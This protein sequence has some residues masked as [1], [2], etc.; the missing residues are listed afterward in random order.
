MRGLSDAVVLTSDHLD[1]LISA[2]KKKNST[3][4]LDQRPEAVFSECALFHMK[5]TATV[6]IFT[7]VLSRGVSGDRK[8]P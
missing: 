1:C 2:K 4:Q 7:I 5:S 8:F 3:A 6:A